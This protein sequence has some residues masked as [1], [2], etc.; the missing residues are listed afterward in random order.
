MYVFFYNHA[1]SVESF[2][3]VLYSI[4]PGNEKEG[5]G[6]IQIDFAG[7]EMQIAQGLS[8]IK[9]AQT[10]TLIDCAPKIEGSSAVMVPGRFN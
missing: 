2:I 5:D 1:T 9:K 4:E 7:R 8:E 10:G 3:C 6:K